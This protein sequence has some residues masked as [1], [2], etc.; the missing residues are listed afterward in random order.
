MGFWCF[1]L[2]MNLLIP[3]TMLGFGLLFQRKPPKT[4]NSIYGYR[5][6]RSMRNQDTWDYAHKV[7][8]ALWVRLGLILL[9]V[10]VCA[11]LPVLGRGAG[12]V[13]IWCCV[14]DGIQLLVLIGS[15]IPVERAL[16][17]T[18]DEFGRR[19]PL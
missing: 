12:A 4:V 14:V 15:I 9:P 16:K 19:R 11:M 10:S 6:T 17:R 5:T 8:G 2:V 3:G 1:C 18:F 13:G 7:C